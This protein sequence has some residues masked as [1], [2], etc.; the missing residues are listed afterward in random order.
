MHASWLSWG[1][2]VTAPQNGQ[3][4][5]REPTFHC[6]VRRVIRRGCKIISTVQANQR[7]ESMDFRPVSSGTMR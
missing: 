5:A 3:E 6:G 4:I 2:P 1:R 7:G